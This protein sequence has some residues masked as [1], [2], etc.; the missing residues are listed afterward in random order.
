MPAEL[1]LALQ[2]QQFHALPEAGGLLDQP[3][4]LLAKM[5]TALN[6]YQAYKAEQDRGNTTLTEW[7]RRN[8]AAWRIFA[9]VERMRRQ[10]NG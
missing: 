2:A 8:P 7:S 9:K 3:Y 1:E 6:V 10:K 4:G 5:S